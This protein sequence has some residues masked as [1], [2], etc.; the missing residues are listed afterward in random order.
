MANDNKTDEYTWKGKKA[1]PKT[2]TAYST[3]LSWSRIGQLDRGGDPV[4]QTFYAA[5]DTFS[6]S[7]SLAAGD[8][9]GL[10][11]H[12]PGD[13]YTSKYHAYHLVLRFTYT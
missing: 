8:L 2:D 5:T 7:N 11:V 10:T 9:I 1:T 13:T 4:A 3:T 6:S 12:N